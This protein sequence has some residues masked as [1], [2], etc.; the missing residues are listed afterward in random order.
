M[1]TDHSQRFL[2]VVRCN[3]VRPWRMMPITP[4]H[5]LPTQCPGA[6]PVPSLRFN[7]YQGSPD[8]QRGSPKAVGLSLTFR[9][10]AEFLRGDVAVATDQLR[11]YPR[12]IRIL[13]RWLGWGTG[14]PG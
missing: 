6:K 3:Q 9:R 2:S 7:L 5:R 10:V 11:N 14:L 4:R 8:R 1:Q 13:E 12:L